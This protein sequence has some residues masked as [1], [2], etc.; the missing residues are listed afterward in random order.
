M[1][2][3]NEVQHFLD[4]FLNPKSIAIYG[5]NENLLQ[6]MAS[7]MLLNAIDDG[8]KGRIYPIHPKLDVVFGLKVYKSILD[9][10]ET[11]D[12]AIVILPKN[13]VPQIF[14]EIGKKGTKNVVL[15]TAGFREVNNAS[16]EEEIK[17]IAKQYGFRFFGPNCL[18]FQNTHTYY[19]ND[20]SDTCILDF[21]WVNYKSNP[22]NV[23][24][25]SQ[26]GTFASHIN[27]LLEERDLHMNKCLSIGNEAN[28]DMCDCLEYF[29]LDPHTQII[30]LY[31]EEIKRGRMFFELVKRIVPK[32]PII[33]LYVGGSEGGSHAVASHTGSMAGNDQIFN[34]LFKQTGIIRVYSVEELMDTAMVFS[35]LVPI[36][37]IPR[38][39][40]L[41]IVTNAGGPGATMSDRATRIG[42]KLPQFS[43]QL[44]SELKK[45]LPP[46]AQGSQAS[47]PL[48]Y[49]FS[50]DP[51]TYFKKVPEILAKSGEVDAMVAYGAYGSD[52]FSYRGIGKEFLKSEKYQ[53]LI[54]MYMDFFE[55]SVE[56]ARR[57]P[58]KYGFPIIYV[59]FMG[60][61]D[62]IV[63]YLNKNGFP[64]FK[65]EHQAINAIANLMKYGE[66][67][68]KIKNR[69]MQLHE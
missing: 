63:P 6:N 41:A 65:N 56:S 36:G 7:Q 24:I 57:I 60:V 15:V 47:N 5:T 58:K 68:E 11:P 17:A 10:P 52:F 53:H 34:G 12:L 61:R 31:I 45:L 23:S 29:E 64:T 25:A 30:L 20:S 13:I 44:Q 1:Q 49:T 37:A 14:H 16:G 38:G 69:N 22:G 19:S 62:A 21:T 42:L 8:Y 43:E 55:G 4:A 54:T 26:S 40:R 67:L 59:N 3:R 66:F 2:S 51:S 46:T 32:K 27:F 9:L 48:D 39:R 28:V 50:I 18:G 35:R 33:A